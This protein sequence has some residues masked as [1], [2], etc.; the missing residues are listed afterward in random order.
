MRA[1]LAYAFGAMSFDSV[2][3]IIE[4]DHVASLRVAEK[5]GFSKFREVVFHEKPVRLY[6][7][8]HDDWTQSHNTTLQGTLRD[9]TAQRP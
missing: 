1:A 8:T 3:V 2:V 7:L 4:P 5:T 6:R 9:E